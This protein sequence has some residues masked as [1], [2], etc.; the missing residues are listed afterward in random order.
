MDTKMLQP[1]WWFTNARSYAENPQDPE[2]PSEQTPQMLDLPSRPSVVQPTFALPSLGYHHEENHSHNLSTT[3]DFSTLAPPI[4][5]MFSPFPTSDG[6]FH[7]P[8]PHQ[9]HHSIPAHFDIPIDSPQLSRPSV[10]THGS[11][12]AKFD[13]AYTIPYYASRVDELLFP[14]PM[15][16]CFDGGMYLG[17][18]KKE[19]SED[20]LHQ[21][22]SKASKGRQKSSSLVVPS[23]K[24]Q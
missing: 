5:P 18:K 8:H 6:D 20:Q 23:L 4:F 10:L 15:L 19:Q 21:N 14:Q 11:D 13:P 9:A 22:A 7:H 16:G 12:A 3:N 2:I 24:K 1:E 17:V